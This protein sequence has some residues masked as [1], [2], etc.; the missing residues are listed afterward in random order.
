V[1]ASRCGYASTPTNRAI[2]SVKTNAATINNILTSLTGSWR[3]KC[4]WNTVRQSATI[5]QQSSL[6]GGN[7]TVT[8]WLRP[9]EGFNQTRG[10]CNNNLRKGE[11]LLPLT[12]W[13]ACASLAVTGEMKRGISG[14]SASDDRAGI[15]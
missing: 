7:V 12:E 11:P 1:G 10:E 6:L 9:G 13:K 2:V 14:T 4:T 5:V 8:T 3:T 15:G